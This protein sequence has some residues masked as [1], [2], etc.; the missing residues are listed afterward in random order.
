MKVT[1]PRTPSAYFQDQLSLKVGD[2][3]KVTRRSGDN[4]EGELNGKVGQIWSWL[5]LN[6]WIPFI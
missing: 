5:S 4:W 1:K 6:K 3:I 2:V